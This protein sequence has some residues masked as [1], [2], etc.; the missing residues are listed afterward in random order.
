MSKPADPLGHRHRDAA[1]WI[2]AGPATVPPLVTDPASSA[3]QPLRIQL[4][5]PAETGNAAPAVH[6][7]RRQPDP[8]DGL[9]DTSRTSSRARLPRTKRANMRADQGRRVAP[10]LAG[11]IAPGTARRSHAPL[12]YDVSKWGTSDSRTLPTNAGSLRHDLK[13]D[14]WVSEP[15]RVVTGNRCVEQLTSPGTAR[16][17]HL[18]SKS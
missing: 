3:R 2:R 5:S 16:S 6:A 1:G 4:R 17:G 8:S 11:V 10:A 14:G 9:P 15:P 13:A 18:R 12:G 7:G